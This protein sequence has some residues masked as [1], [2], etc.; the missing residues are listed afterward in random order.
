MIYIWSSCFVDTICLIHINRS[1]D[2]SVSNN[3]GFGNMQNTGTGAGYCEMRNQCT[4]NCFM[5]ECILAAYI[6]GSA[7][8]VILIRTRGPSTQAKAMI[9]FSDSQY[10]DVTSEA[11]L[12]SVATWPFSLLSSFYSYEYKIRIAHGGNEGG[13][14]LFLVVQEPNDLMSIAGVKPNL[15]LQEV[16]GKGL[17][18][19]WSECTAQ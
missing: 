2:L 7:R 19:K 11:I 1:L 13:L 14:L 8:V 12:G 5:S 3:I 9:S 4:F 16:R 17:I 10:T 6:F 15:W 18:Q